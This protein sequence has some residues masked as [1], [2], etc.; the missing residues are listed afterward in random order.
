MSRYEIDVSGDSFKILSKYVV[1][2]MTTFTK[3]LMFIIFDK[4]GIGELNYQS[5]FA[6]ILTSQ[7]T[8]NLLHK[9]YKD[10]FMS[11]KVALQFEDG[12]TR[13]IEVG[14]GEVL[15]DAAYRQKMNIPLDCRDGACGTCRSFL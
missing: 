5:H 14:D 8:A 6:L 12:V 10:I 15:S 3:S 9:K 7:P 4:N 13:F 11:H 2:K 1:L